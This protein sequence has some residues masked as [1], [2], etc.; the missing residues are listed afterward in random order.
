VLV[1]ACSRQDDIVERSVGRHV[2]FG[3]E[4]EGVKPAGVVCDGYRVIFGSVRR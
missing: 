3:L 2:L 1:V 4:Q